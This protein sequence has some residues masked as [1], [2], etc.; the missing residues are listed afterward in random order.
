MKTMRVMENGNGLFVLQEAVGGG[1]WMN[2]ASYD[3]EAEALEAFRQFKE[4]RRAVRVIVED[5]V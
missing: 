3:T 5:T 1:E 4:D 2:H